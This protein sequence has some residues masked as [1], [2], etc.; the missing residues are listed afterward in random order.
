M[1]KQ[2][3]VLMM[4]AAAF[5]AGTVPAA[6]ADVRVSVPFA[7]AAGGA[8]LPAGVYQF[9]QNAVSGVLSVRD[10][11]AN[12]DVLVATVPNAS[13][14]NVRPAAVVFERSPEGYRLT[15]VRMADSRNLGV[16]AAGGKT[17]LVA[18]RQAPVELVELT[19]GQ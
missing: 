19:V 16:P 6:A 17:P 10:V 18:V 1:K 5:V 2:I 7:F 13:A 12:R 8:T 11:H 14:H 4:A 3:A 9:S 15:Q